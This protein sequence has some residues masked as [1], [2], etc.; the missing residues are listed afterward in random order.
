MN[1]NQVLGNTYLLQWLD[2]SIN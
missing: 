2:I 1:I